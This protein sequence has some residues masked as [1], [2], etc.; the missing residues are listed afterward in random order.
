MSFLFF[1]SFQKPFRDVSKD[2]RHRLG[3]FGKWE[4]VLLLVLKLCSRSSSEIKCARLLMCS[5]RS[6]YYWKLK[7]F[8]RRVLRTLPPAEYDGG[9]PSSRRFSSKVSKSKTRSFRIYFEV[10]AVL[11]SASRNHRQWRYEWLFCFGAKHSS[12]SV[13]VGRPE[14]QFLHF[15]A[16]LD[17]SAFEFEVS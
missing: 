2:Y 3:Y 6:R 11:V 13:A 12:W 5:K 1:L 4:S 16:P 9:D 7:R 10:S 8:R 14:G 15:T 17:L